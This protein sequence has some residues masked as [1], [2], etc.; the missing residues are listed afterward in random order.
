MKGRKGRKGRKA[1]WNL[2]QNSRLVPQCD[3]HIKPHK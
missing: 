3:A 2:M 1:T